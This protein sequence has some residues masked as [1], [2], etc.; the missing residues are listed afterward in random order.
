MAK[1]HEILAVE[2]DLASKARAEVDRVLETFQSGRGRFLGQ[3]RTY[4]PREEGGETLPK[5]TTPLARTVGNEIDAFWRVFGDWLDTSSAKEI[6]NRMTSGSVIVEGEEVAVLE[7]LPAP[8]LL[9][10]ENKLAILRRV[11]AGIPTHDPL[12]VWEEDQNTGVMVSRA[13][14]VRTKKVPR[15]HTLAKATKE[16]PAQVEM[17]ME[18]IT[19]GDWMTTIHS[20]MVSHVEKR[21]FLERIDSLAREVK[22]ARQRANDREQADAREIAAF[23]RGY[24]HGE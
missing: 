15:S 9:N 19:V 18:D 2:G 17:W 6:T 16:H 20:G 14:S 13:T 3:S 8:A 24:I 7:Q 1:L 22:R 12:K 21:D 11:Y 4:E 5:E 23:I 10:L